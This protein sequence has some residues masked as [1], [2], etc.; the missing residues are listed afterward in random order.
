MDG[1]SQFYFP[2]DARVLRQFL[3]F[4][5]RDKKINSHVI[6]ITMSTKTVLQ[7]NDLQR[8]IYL[9]FNNSGA[10]FIQELNPMGPAIFKM[11]EK[12]LGNINNKVLYILHEQRIR[13][14]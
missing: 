7:N 4:F 9:R 12:M 6:N 11:N 8:K 1:C 14:L 2:N 10:I 13:L 3:N 5:L